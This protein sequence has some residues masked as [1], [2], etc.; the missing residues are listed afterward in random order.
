MTLHMKHLYETLDTHL[1]VVSITDMFMYC[2]GEGGEVLLHV[3]HLQLLLHQRGPWRS[4]EVVH[5]LSEGRQD[6]VVPEGQPQ[7]P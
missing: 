1:V 4:P 3:D 6:E 2:T 7:G 5:F